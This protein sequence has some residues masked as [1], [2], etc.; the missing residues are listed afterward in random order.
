[1]KAKIESMTPKEWK[2]PEG[3][4]KKFYDV[5]FEGNDKKYGCWQFDL[6]SKQKVG[7]EI[8]IT[9][10]EKNGRFSFTLSGAAKPGFAPR[11][12]SPEEL[13]LQK[14]SF[15]A[16]YSKDLVVAF[17]NKGVLTD[18]QSCKDNLEYFVPIFN[19]LLGG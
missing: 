2:N 7:D 19:K 16:S 3:Q 11:G 6:L 5:T 18:A 4:I 8:D 17:I 15:A 12:K 13:S 14:N 10:V 9:E 1:M